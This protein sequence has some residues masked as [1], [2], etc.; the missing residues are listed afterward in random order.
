MRSHTLAVLG[1]EVSFKAEMYIN[2][3]Y[4]RTYTPAKHF[5]KSACDEVAKDREKI[6]NSQMKKLGL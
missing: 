4:E 2:K 6:F 3:R 5:F 1:L